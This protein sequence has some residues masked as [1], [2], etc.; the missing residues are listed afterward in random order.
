MNAAR[1]LGA[2]SRQLMERLRSWLSEQPGW[3]RGVLAGAAVLVLAVVVFAVLWGRNL[4]EAALY[5]NLPANQTG[6]VSAA[7]D[8][9]GIPYRMDATGI[10]T[11]PEERLHAIRMQLAEDGLPR[12]DV[13][14]Y[15]LLDQP[16]GFGTSDV[17]EHQRLQRALEGELAHSVESVAGIRQARVH[18]ALPQQAVFVHDARK[19]SASVLV[20]MRPGHT[21]SKKQIGAIQH[22]VAASVVELVPDQVA[23]VDQE[24]HLLSKRDDE[25]DDEEASALQLQVAQQLEASYIKRI[26]GLL[27]PLV[28]AEG[29]RA[30]VN[31]ELDW[32]RRDEAEELFHPEPRALRSEQLKSTLRE[33]M[34]PPM[35]VPGAL[36]NQPPAAGTAPQVVPGQQP[37]QQN[38]NQQNPPREQ[39]SESTRNWEIGNTVRHT[40]YAPGAIKRLTVAVMVDDRFIKQQ[41]GIVNRVPWNDEEISRLEKLVKEAVGFDEQRGDSVNVINASFAAPA[42]AVEALPWWRDPLLWDQALKLAWWLLALMV[43]LLLFRMLRDRWQAQQE[44]E[45]QKHEQQKLAE[46][47]AGVMAGGETPTDSKPQVEVVTPSALEDKLQQIKRT[48][49]QE[50]K[51][52]AQVVRNWLKD[53]ERN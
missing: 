3:R 30:Q 18:L 15:E 13:R 42:G 7:L 10:I 32:S 35:G 45:R 25:T 17:M 14:G 16:S 28:G 4:R 48:A 43:A 22:L 5:P 52:V 34:Q 31:A 29:V 8:A 49:R 26:Q 38:Q 21:L 37:N 9:R 1:D 44:L 27:E 50:P 2:G 36:T 6:A 12:L 20:V 51:L 11:V 24:G 46:R 23:V 53:D 41:G 39:S 47:L 33:G 19:P 40:K